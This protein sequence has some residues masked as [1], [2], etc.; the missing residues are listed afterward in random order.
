MGVYYIPRNLDVF[1]P[2]PGTL[3]AYRDNDS[4][5]QGCPKF[6]VLALRVSFSQGL[7]NCK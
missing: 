4:V 5:F 3:R 2:G 7:N 6:N 1:I